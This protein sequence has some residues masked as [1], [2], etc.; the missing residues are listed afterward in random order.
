MDIIHQ[1]TQ[2]IS[3]LSAGEQ[4]E[5]SAKA[6]WLSHSDFHS[7]AVYLNRE[8]EKGLFSIQQPPSST[9]CES[10]SMVKIIKH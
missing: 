5:I 4:W 8:S 9:L 2:K 6:L 1:I 10:V 3:S 7:I